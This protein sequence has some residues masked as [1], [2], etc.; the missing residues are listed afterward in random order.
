VEGV[1]CDV[2]APHGDRRV[3]VRLARKVARLAAADYLIRV[4]RRRV[5]DEPFVRLPRV[6]PVLACRP[7]DASPAPEL[8][9]WALTM[10]DVEL[11]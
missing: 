10:G 6:G 5:T 7:L 4:D 8:S 2:L 11:F 9:A 1:L 3:A